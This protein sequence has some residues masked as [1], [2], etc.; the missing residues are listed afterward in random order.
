M[1]NSNVIIAAVLVVAVFGGIFLSQNLGLW[2]TTNI[3]EPEELISVDSDGLPNPADIRGS[4]TF[5]DVSTFY[6][7]PLDAIFRSFPLENRDPNQTVNVISESYELSTNDEEIGVD[8]IRLLVALYDGLAYEAED[9]TRLPA[10]ALDVLAERL[11]PAD[12]DQLR[13]L[14][15]NA[16][17]VDR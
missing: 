13:P 7:I 2:I 6:D 14:A 4:F 15:I 3:R 5:D 1:K 11:A 8:S 12:L 9:T 17:P 16:V 10:T